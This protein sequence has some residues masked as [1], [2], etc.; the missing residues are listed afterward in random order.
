[1]TRIGLAPMKTEKLTIAVVGLCIGFLLWRALS[2]YQPDTAAHAAER[3]PTV[4]ERLKTATI[5]YN[6][7]LGLRCVSVPRTGISC[8]WANWK[9]DVDNRKTTR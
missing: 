6:T 1:M 2:D 4:A 9:K 7:S 8:D 3:A 5:H